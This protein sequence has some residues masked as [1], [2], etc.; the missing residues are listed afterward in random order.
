MSIIPYSCQI[1][2]WNNKKRAAKAAAAKLS[3]AA[4]ASNNQTILMRADRMSNCAERIEYAYCNDCGN[5]SIAKTYLCRDRLCPVCTWRLSIKRTAELWRVFEV[6]TAAAAAGNE[7]RQPLNVAML[8][9][10]VKNCELAE[11]G[12]T[13]DEMLKAWKKLLK[14]RTIV[15]YVKGYARSIEITRG[16][17]GTWHPHIHAIIIFSS[18]YKNQISQ[19]DFCELWRE[20]LGVEYIPI[21][22]VRKVYSKKKNDSEEW[23]KITAAIIEAC[24]YAVKQSTI[25]SANI[26]DIIPLAEAVKGKVLIAYGGIIREIRR[27]LKMSDSERLEEA[28]ELSIEC[29]KCGNMNLVNLIYEW[30]EGS[31][32]LHDIPNYRIN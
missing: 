9:L 26:E 16:K 29:P 28:P 8:T 2:K 32:I 27:S 20:S 1:E 3:A 19:A 10:T 5:L 30:G 11:L 4:A 17:N 25:D 13:I 21:C 7:G 31:Y 14:R 24:K 12:N 18:D 6:L 23:N 22:D 15:R